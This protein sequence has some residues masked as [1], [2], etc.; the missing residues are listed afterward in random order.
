MPH[1]L[2]EK[3]DTDFDEKFGDVWRMEEDASTTESGKP[4][5]VRINRY[6][7]SYLYSRD[8]SLIEAI[9][10]AIQ[11]EKMPEDVRREKTE[12]WEAKGYNSAIDRFTKILNSFKLKR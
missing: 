7:K 12:S 3:L 5:F 1:P 9:E 6:L 2:I 10:E 4:K 8:S 11:A